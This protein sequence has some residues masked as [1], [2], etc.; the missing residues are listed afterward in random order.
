LATLE[1]ITEEKL[2]ERAD[3]ISFNTVADLRGRLARHPLVREV[4]ALGLL[5]GVEISGAN[6]VDTAERVMYAALR[7][8]LNFK[9]S[10]GT[11][12]TFAPPLNVLEEEL[13]QAWSILKDSLDEVATTI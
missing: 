9:V 4:R 6:A 11:V 13:D 8:G 7:R 5:I 12:L 1:V 2:V 10:K 3:R